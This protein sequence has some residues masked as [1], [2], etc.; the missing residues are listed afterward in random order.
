MFMM[1]DMLLVVHAVECYAVHTVLNDVPPVI[2]RSVGNVA[3]RGYYSVA[4]LLN[5]M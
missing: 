3:M 2:L 4:G 5:F 1:T